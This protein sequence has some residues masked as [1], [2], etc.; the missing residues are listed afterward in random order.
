MGLSRHT[1]GFIISIQLGC[2]TITF[3]EIHFDNNQL[4]NF[5]M[6]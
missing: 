2:L 6:E 1:C 4:R 3:E 5:K